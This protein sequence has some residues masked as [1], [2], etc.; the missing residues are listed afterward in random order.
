MS[1]RRAAADV[2]AGAAFRIAACVES[3]GHPLR[4]RIVA[5]GYGR[6]CELS[7]RGFADAF[8]LEPRA[9]NYHFHKLAELGLLTPDGTQRRRGGVERLYCVSAAGVQ[10][11]AALGE[12]IANG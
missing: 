9:V 1:E 3:I 2:G 6:D 5:W 7:P 12:V 4:L 10:L 11:L 8:E